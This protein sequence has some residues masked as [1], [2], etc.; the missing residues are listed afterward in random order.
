MFYIVDS[1]VSYK[2]ADEPLKLYNVVVSQQ[3]EYYVTAGGSSMHRA[4]MFQMSANKNAK[5]Q[6][7]DKM[8]QVEYSGNDFVDI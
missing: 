6:E 3:D 8:N 4:R 7:A 2:M 5:E 1:F